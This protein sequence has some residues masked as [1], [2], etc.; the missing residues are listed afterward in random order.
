MRNER[1]QDVR[2]ADVAEAIDDCG[3]DTA[4]EVL[5]PI[6]DDGVVTQRAVETAVSDTSKLL[7]T[8]ETRVELAGNAYAD[9]VDAADPVADLPVVRTRLDGFAERLSAV[10][11]RISE[12]RPDLGVPADALERPRSVYDVAAELRDVATTAQGIIRTADDLS[13]DI[14]QFR[15][16]L[17]RSSRR[18]DE[19]EKDLNLVEDSIAGLEITVERPLSDAAE[20][21]SSDGNGPAA[22]WADA[23]MQVDVVALLIA[24][25]R[26]E[27]RDL[28][29]FAER[30][31]DPFRSDLRDRIERLD[32]RVSA[33]DSTLDRGADRA[34]RDR[35]EDDI[36][37][38]ES[39]LATFDPPVDW[40]AVDRTL[41]SHRPA[42]TGAKT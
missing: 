35:F 6:T 33:I 12:L 9:A 30:T 13:F 39:E 11:T 34:W 36:A 37:T 14:E 20:T 41:Q 5:D 32:S 1:A 38:F 19:F 42:G 40:G 15:S 10:N 28:R 27:L 18:Y 29:A 2:A 7:A 3:L 4:R 8:A 24:D 23:T 17:D 21:R 16:W 25:L 26:A 31:D 22:E